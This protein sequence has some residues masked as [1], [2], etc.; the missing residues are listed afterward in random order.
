MGFPKFLSGFISITSGCFSNT[1]SG[2]MFF[3]SKRKSNASE[4]T[5]FEE[6]QEAAKKS[7]SSSTSSSMSKVWGPISIISIGKS[8]SIERRTFTSVIQLGLEF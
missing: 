1:F 6:A 4:H 2:F 7:S 5:V 8:F 3:S